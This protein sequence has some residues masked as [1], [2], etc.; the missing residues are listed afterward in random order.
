MFSP[1]LTST[2]TS[3]LPILEP[4]TKKAIDVISLNSREEE[5]F[6]L[7]RE[8]CKHYKLDNVTLR[9]AGGW[10]RD[11]MLGLSSMDCD[12]AIDTMMGEKF[13]LLFLEFLKHRGIPTTSY[14]V[15]HA[16]P[17]KSKH[18]ETAT[19]SLLGYP[20]D[21]VNLR[22]EEY[23][24]SSRIPNQITFGTPYEDAMRRDFTVNS[25]FLNLN[26]SLLEDWTRFW[27]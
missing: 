20:L 13:A 18:L 17:T 16:N 27:F 23:S 3:S 5:I 19:L 15:I 22:S 2:S 4:I 7:L 21:F 1:S 14:G 10:V 12:I 6:G 11:K 26:T 8:C 25:L 24:S 9:V